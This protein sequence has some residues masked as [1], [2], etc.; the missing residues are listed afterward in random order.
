[1]KVIAQLLAAGLLTWFVLMVLLIAVRMLRRDIRVTGLLA[2]TPPGAGTAIE[3]ERGVAMAAFP[4]VLMLYVLSALQ[5]DL[6]VVDG[7]PVMPDVPN[8][9]LTILTGG[10]GLYLAGKIARRK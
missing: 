7:R 6:P 3:P 2:E 8:Y 10:N 4:L 1:M 9:L 5:T